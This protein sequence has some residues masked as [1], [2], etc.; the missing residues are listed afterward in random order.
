MQIGFTDNTLVYLSDVSCW[1]KFKNIFVYV[2]LRS[3]ISDPNSNYFG[4]YGPL[5]VGCHAPFFH[6]Q[7]ADSV[8]R[9]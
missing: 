7:I 4:S 2:M 8:S 1:K 6:S 5:K 3:K 9:G